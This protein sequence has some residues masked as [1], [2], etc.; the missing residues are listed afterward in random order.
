MTSK[1]LKSSHELIKTSIFTSS[2]LPIYF[3]WWD[4]WVLKRIINYVCWF[5]DAIDFETNL[6]QTKKKF[7]FVKI[8]EQIIIT[9]AILL[10]LN[11]FYNL[12]KVSFKINCICKSANII[13][14]SFEKPWVSSNEVVWKDTWGKNRSFLKLTHEK[15]LSVCWSLLFLLFFLKSKTILFFFFPEVCHR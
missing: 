3:I 12:K 5:T 9:T 8:A 6:L 10:N 14:D 4:P 1:R 15:F 11:F 13:Y 7:K 2:V